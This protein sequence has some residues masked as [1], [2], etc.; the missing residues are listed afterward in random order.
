M[1]K[2]KGL[3]VFTLVVSLLLVGGVMAIPTLTVNI[4]KAAMGDGTISAPASTANVNLIPTSDGLSL[5]KVDVKFDQDLAA[6]AV[7]YVYVYDSN[8]QLLDSTSV[9]LQ[10]AVT[11]GNPVTVDLPNNPAMQD[12]DNIK[13]LVLGPQY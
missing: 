6:G 7:V 2:F 13:V 12:V 11:S 1:K 4:Q 3:M 10:N 5:D 8:N 9:T